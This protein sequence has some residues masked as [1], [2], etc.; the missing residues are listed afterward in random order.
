MDLTNVRA[1]ICANVGAIPGLNTLPNPPDDGTEPLF[2]I[3]TAEVAYDQAMGGGLD[4]VTFD[5]FVIASRAD[6]TAGAALIN[7]YLAGSGT[8]SIREKV[9]T[10]RQLGGSAADVRLVTARG[11]VSIQLAGIDYIGAHLSIWV[12]GR[13]SA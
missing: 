6:D 3:G 5:C 4:V 10:D 9:R 2:W 12:A 8:T 13:G 11:P 7:S 1:G